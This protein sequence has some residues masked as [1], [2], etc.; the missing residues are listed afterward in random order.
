MGRVTIDDGGG[1]GGGSAAVSASASTPS[2]PPASGRCDSV[3]TVTATP[4][5]PITTSYDDGEYVDD[6]AEYN[7]DV[8]DDNVFPDDNLYRQ[9]CRTRHP[10]LWVYTASSCLPYGSE[11]WVCASRTRAC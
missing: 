4:T 8:D 1:G 7:K 9:L 6:N 11:V 2:P 10:A 3:R 5:M